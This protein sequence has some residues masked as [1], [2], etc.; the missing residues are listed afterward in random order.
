M[1]PGPGLHVEWVDDEAVVLDTE[2]GRLHYLNSSAALTWA[3][4]LEH[5]VDEA[6]RR[7]SSSHANG[8]EASAELDALLA[9]LA[10]RGL[11]VDD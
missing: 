11:L 3:L 10:D 5:G 4:I 6:V 9:D 8:D 7:V 2:T 1:R